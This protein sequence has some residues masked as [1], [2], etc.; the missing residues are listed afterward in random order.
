MT[1]SHFVGA[2]AAFAAGATFVGIVLNLSENNAILSV[3]FT[4]MTFV[5]LIGCYVNLRG[6]S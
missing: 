1:Q 2:L 6:D 4:V 3:L 5:N